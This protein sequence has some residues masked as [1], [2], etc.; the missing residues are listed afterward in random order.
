[1]PCAQLTGTQALFAKILQRNLDAVVVKL[2]IIAAELVTPIGPAMKKLAD[3]P[4]GGIRLT[5]ELCRAADVDRTV[6]FVIIYIMIDLADQ[7]AV[8]RL[9]AHAQHLGARAHRGDVLVTPPLLIIKA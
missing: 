3:H 6:K 7:W 5:F 4:D 2:L 1:M 9:A 8:G